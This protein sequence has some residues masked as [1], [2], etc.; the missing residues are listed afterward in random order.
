MKFEVGFWREHILCCESVEATTIGGA[1]V[2]A[3]A[4]V[5][6]KIFYIRKAERQSSKEH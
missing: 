3:L 4:T 2:L 1:L 5:S 6:D